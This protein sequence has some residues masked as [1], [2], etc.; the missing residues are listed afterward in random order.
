MS[1]GNVASV[2]SMVNKAQLHLQ[3]KYATLSHYESEDLKTQRRVKINNKVAM[4]S[5]RV[6]SQVQLKS[7]RTLLAQQQQGARSMLRML[8]HDPS[9]QVLNDSASTLP[10]IHKTYKLPVISRI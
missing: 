9:I 2:I 7:Q 6:A 4:V 1:D 8:P 3:Q 10:D 5:A